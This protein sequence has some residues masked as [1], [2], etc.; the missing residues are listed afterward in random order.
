MRK[1]SCLFGFIFL[2][3]VLLAP[4]SAVASPGA[5]ESGGSQLA[6]A[7]GQFLELVTNLLAGDLGHGM[8][9]WDGADSPDATSSDG[10]LGPGWDPWG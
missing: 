2:L 10:D 9:P 1:R 8:G 3:V 4:G 6:A 7:W 5:F